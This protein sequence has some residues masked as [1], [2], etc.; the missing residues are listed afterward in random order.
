MKN[1]SPWAARALSRLLVMVMALLVGFAPAA[2]Q[3]DSTARSNASKALIN[4]ST[5]GGISAAGGA[6]ATDVGQSLAKPYQ[7]PYWRRALGRF[8]AGTSSPRI[9]VLGDSTAAGVGSANALHAGNRVG[10]MPAHLA[11]CLAQSFGSTAVRSDWLIGDGN[12]AKWDDGS[13]TQSARNAQFV[14]AWT[15]PYSV[16]LGNGWNVEN[17]A[18]LGGYFFTNS[19]T[20]DGSLDWKCTLACDRVEIGVIKDSGPRSLEVFGAGGSAGVVDLANASRI[21]VTIQI[22]LPTRAVQTI[23]I[24]RVSGT[25]R[26]NWIKPYDSTTPQIAVGN[27]GRGSVAAFQLGDATTGSNIPFSPMALQQAANADVTVI[28]LGF[29][30]QSSN[31][32]PSLYKSRYQNIITAAKATG[33]AIPVIQHPRAPSDEALY[34][35]PTSD[36]QQAVR[37][38][39]ATNSTP[40]LDYYTRFGSYA[41]GSTLGYYYDNTHFLSPGY[42]DQARALCNILVN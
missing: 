1:A 23:S 6:L 28:S 37:E 22:T 15:S 19:T 30:D 39:A 21:F 42:A 25:V 31:T 11:S 40:L 16:A 12:S 32:T 36:Y 33:D 7:L 26:V 2:A 17:Q 4:S 8:S 18:G 3:I 14:S 35:Y 10:S 41:L 38:L 27:A 9:L 34:T 20:T 29:N 24:K 13:L 5:P